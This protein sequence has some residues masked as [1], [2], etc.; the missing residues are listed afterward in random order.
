MFTDFDEVGPVFMA[1][2]DLLCYGAFTLLTC[3][4]LRHSL[5]RRIYSF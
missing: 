4:L 3:F 5:S 2:I 1:L